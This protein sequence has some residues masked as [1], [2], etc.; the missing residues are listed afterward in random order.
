MISSSSVKAES[1]N[2]PSDQ[3]FIPCRPTARTCQQSRRSNDR[4]VSLSV[5]SSKVCSSVRSL[6]VWASFKSQIDSH[7]PSA[8]SLAF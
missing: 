4:Q 8:A 6:V 5:T 1:S 3:S 7:N 2:P